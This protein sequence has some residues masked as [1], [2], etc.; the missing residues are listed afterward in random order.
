MPQLDGLRAFAALGVVLSHT[1][2]YNSGFDLGI[3]SVWLFFCL[4]SFLITRILVQARD[5]ADEGG[6]GYWVPWRSFWIRR[7]LRIFALYYAAIAVAVLLGLGT[8]RQDWPWLVTYTSNF[9]QFLL[10]HPTAPFGHFWSLAVEEQ[11]Y[12]TWPIACLLLPRRAL[13]GFSIACVA[14]GPIARILVNQMTNHLFISHWLMPTCLD[15]LGLGAVL[16]ISGRRPSSWL[17]VAAL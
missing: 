6:Y 5:K 15:A 9:Q 11:V 12:L 16:A 17:L 14:S 7:A 3:S 8:S 4:S 2:P 1:T 10:R 13:L